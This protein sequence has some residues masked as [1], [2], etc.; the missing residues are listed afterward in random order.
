MLGP[1]PEDTGRAFELFNPWKKPLASAAKSSQIWSRLLTADVSGAATATEGDGHGGE[2]DAGAHDRGRDVDVLV[3]SP[4]LPAR[5][6][7]DQRRPQPQQEGS[8]R[9][10]DEE[11]EQV[12]NGGHQVDD[13]ERTDEQDGV[14]HVMA[15]VDREGGGVGRAPHQHPHRHG[16]DHALL[17][18]AEPVRRQRGVDAGRP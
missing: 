12:A 14:E 9:E 7:L 11:P 17:D 10:Q 6:T 15:A 2:Q 16:H 3:H 8:E 5:P 13:Q 18:G 1:N 4:L